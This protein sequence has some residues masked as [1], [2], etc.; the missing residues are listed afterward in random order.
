MKNL[1]VLYSAASLESFF[2]NLNKK[3]VVIDPYNQTNIGNSKMQK[4]EQLRELNRW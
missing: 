1:D 4:F 2:N 3:K